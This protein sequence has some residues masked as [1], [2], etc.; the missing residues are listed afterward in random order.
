M[1]IQIAIDF[2][3]FHFTKMAKSTL[4][5]I[6]I[7]VTAKNIAAN[8][9][10]DASYTDNCHYDT[11]YLN[12]KC[13]D[14]CP[15]T[16]FSKCYCGSSKERSNHCCLPPESRC[17]IQDLGRK[18][19]KN[20]TI[21]DVVC[22]D[23]QNYPSYSWRNQWYC[24][25]NN[26]S[27]HCYNS[28]Q[29][30]EYIGSDSHYTCP[31]KCVPMLEMCNGVS[32][33]DG[34]QQVCGPDLR[35][36]SDCGKSS[37]PSIAHH[38]CFH[39][40]ESTLKYNDELSQINNGIFNF[41]GRTDEEVI[42]S[43]ELSLSAILAMDISSFILC[44]DDEGL[45][46]VEDD[47][48]LDCKEFDDWCDPDFSYTCYTQ[49]STESGL[50]QTNNMHL[51]KNPLLWNGMPCNEYNEGLRCTGNYMGRCI[52]PWYATDNGLGDENNCVDKSDQKF[53]SG[54]TCK[55]NLEKN[56]LYHDE[57]FCHEGSYLEDQLI[58]TNKAQWMLEENKTYP[59]DNIFDPHFCEL[60][61]SV[62]GWGGYF[63]EIN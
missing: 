42:K 16:S 6:F 41:I 14:L 2:H 7:A 62:P 55:E 10:T 39:D 40:D 34:D 29:H 24:D 4:I 5:L 44:D 26:S 37:I 50:I 52:F 58:C 56:M 27:L 36:C 3:E 45:V 54:L 49:H 60:S 38:W 17:E 22:P 63:V 9:M 43:E 15:P 48:D 59:E 31:D 33:C 46:C 19:Y 47:G 13:G 8:E 23:G 25:S 21:L 57:T 51:C 28:Y 30:S 32:F 11:S 61:C 1:Y 12:F 53:K 20:E 35:C 18:D